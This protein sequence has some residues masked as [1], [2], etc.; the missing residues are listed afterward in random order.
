M[1]RSAHE[2]V[3]HACVRV[4]AALV[5]KLRQQGALAAA[6]LA[7]DQHGPGRRGG[8]VVVQVSQQ[9]PPPDA[10]RFDDVTREGDGA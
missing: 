8:G 10:R 2:V 1:R 3:Q 7:G 9:V 4:A 5:H 6:G